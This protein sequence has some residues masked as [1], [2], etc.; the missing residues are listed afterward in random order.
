MAITFRF[1]IF[2][3]LAAGIGWLISTAAAP[4][5]TAAEY[6]ARAFA[7]FYPDAATSIALDGLERS[8]TAQPVQR[9]R[10]L[11]FITRALTHAR[12]SGGQFAAMPSPA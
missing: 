4:F 3:I 10:F 9:S 7:Y 11:S 1:S 8:S 5:H 6:G 12:F 2:S